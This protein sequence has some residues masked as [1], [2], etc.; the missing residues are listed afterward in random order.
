MRF[1]RLITT[2][3]S[4]TAGEN[5]RV[6]TGGIPYIPGS[7]IVEKMEYC[8][9]E[10]DSLRTALMY[11]PRG[12]SA[13]FGCILTNPTRED[14]DLGII[15]MGAPGYLDMC[16]HALIGAATVAIETGII[17][18][19]EPVTTVK[20]DTCAG[21]V[22]TKAEIE[23]GR[24]KNI[25]FRNVASFLYKDNVPVEVPRLGEISV[26]ISFGGIFTAIVSAK[27]L[28]I[29]VNPEHSNEILNLGE[30]ILGA[31]N[32]Q[33][34]VKHPEN[35]H[36]KATSQ[37][38]ITDDPSNPLA[39]YRNAVVCCHG[40]RSRRAIDRSPCGTGTCARMAQLYSIGELG[41][42]QDF[43]HESII[44]TLFKGKLVEETRIG[45]Y[46]AVIPEVTGSSYIT[47]FHQFIIDP[48]DPLK[49]G[50][51]I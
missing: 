26:D 34:E 39:N 51:L 3:D 1:E 17:K 40:S 6:I 24:P 20:W 49:Y 21:L 31:L 35:P 13:M 27:R 32:E 29:R 14:A 28:G 36:I 30:C 43:I 33:V 9:R 2:I 7:T 16:G 10:L 48:E 46:R 18:A 19:V 47:G 23:D 37:V 42:H 11:E 12:Y 5:V 8:K 41:I 38:M 22:T 45:T 4:H 15:F 50:F 25:T 44:G